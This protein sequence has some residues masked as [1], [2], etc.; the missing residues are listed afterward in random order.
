[1]P[2]YLVRYSLGENNTYEYPK[3]LAGVV[4]KSAMYHYTDQAMVGETDAALEADGR[5]ITSLTSE[6]A[7]KLIEEYQVSHPKPKDLPD[8]LGLP[9]T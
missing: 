1:M 4:W 5:Q 9:R 7:K 3:N 6:E 8:P 2:Y